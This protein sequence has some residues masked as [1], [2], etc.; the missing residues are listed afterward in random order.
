MEILMSAALC[1][2]AA[3]FCNIIKKTARTN[4][5]QTRLKK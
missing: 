3:S 1:T 4:L 5:Q 2:F